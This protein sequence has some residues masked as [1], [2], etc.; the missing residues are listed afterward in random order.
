MAVM[1]PC[2]VLKDFFTVFFS[3]TF[4]VTETVCAQVIDAGTSR[5]KESTAEKKFCFF[6]AVLFRNLQLYPCNFKKF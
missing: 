6:I 5:N 1:V 2:G 4:P 3:Y